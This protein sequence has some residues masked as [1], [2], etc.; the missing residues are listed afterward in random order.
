VRDGVIF[1]S[2]A[3]IKDCKETK[4]MTYGDILIEA[5][6]EATGE[7]KEELTFLLGVF[8]KQFPKANIDQ[9]LSDA[10]AHDL[11]EKLRKDKDSIRDF[12]TT[13]EF[14]Q[15]D[16]DSGDCKGGHS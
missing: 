13:G 10:E 8:R 12:F 11:L 15:G 1:A 4:K 6:A 3:L 7:S 9:E 14:P 5:M 16:C 2:A